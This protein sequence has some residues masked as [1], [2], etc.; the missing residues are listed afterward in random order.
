MNMYK[1]GMLLSE[2][3][4]K[5]VAKEKVLQYW[6]R[7]LQNFGRLDDVLIVE[8]AIFAIIEDPVRNLK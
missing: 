4:A 2:D 3:D 7:C 8:I 6:G 5:K 1:T